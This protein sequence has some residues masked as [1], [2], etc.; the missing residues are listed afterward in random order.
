[1][2]RKDHKQ[3]NN[4]EETLSGKCRNPKNCGSHPRRKVETEAC[5]IDSV[6]PGLL[7]SPSVVE[8]SYQDVKETPRLP[9]KYGRGWLLEPNPSFK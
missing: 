8:S 9:L 7:Q 2:L 3:W 1:M 6:W 5:R 4:Q